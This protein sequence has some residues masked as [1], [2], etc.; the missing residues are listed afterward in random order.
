MLFTHEI[1]SSMVPD[2]KK[3]IEH[4]GMTYIKFTQTYRNII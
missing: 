3:P 4:I 2:F 1:N